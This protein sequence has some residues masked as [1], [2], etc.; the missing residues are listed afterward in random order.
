MVKK[1]VLFFSSR[2]LPRHYFYLSSVLI[3]LLYLKP[4][5]SVW[6]Y[7]D[8]YGLFEKNLL[9]GRHAIK[10]GNL[11]GGIIFNYFS[12]W[13][14][15]S[16]ADLWRLR[17]I[18]LALLLLIMNSIAKE[19]NRSNQSSLIQ[20]ALPLTLMLPAP[21]TFICW[22]L[23]WQGS[24]GIFL[25]FYASQCWLNSHSY[26]RF[27]APV[28]VSAAMTISPVSTFTY[29]GFFSSI[30]ILS[31]ISSHVYAKKLLKLIL[32]FIISG[33]ITLIVLSVYK[34]F[35]D[36]VLNPRVGLVKL[37]DIPEK[38]FWLISRP[39]AVSTR[40]FDIHSPELFN[41]LIVFS[42]VI[43]IVIF[44]IIFQSRE[45]GESIFVRMILYFICLLTSITPIIITWSNQIEYRYI[46]GM[47]WSLFIVTLFLLSEVIGKRIKLT[48]TLT[49]VSIVSVLLAG[50]TTV[51]INT[52]K[53]FIAPYISKYQFLSS[54]IHSCAKKTSTITGVIIMNPQSPFPSRG[55]LG[56]FSQITD[57]ESPWVPIP[58][59][60]AVLEEKGFLN[61]KI[62]VK[63][64]GFKEVNKYC[65]ID[66]EKY[67]KILVASL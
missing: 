49:T 28:I 40:F 38:A 7:S 45:I 9:L 48:K 22:G 52:N 60:K 33:F 24:L 1:L 19:V 58:S 20:F 35:F 4:I 26:K 44:G 67:R 61:V 63:E 36:L 17:L 34:K 27:I 31:K 55:N 16:P 50:I 62:S 21:M 23:L 29:F 53:Q 64:V 15:N 51:S 65:V 54:E 10:D 46:F 11:L 43:G 18:S 2:L 56:I 39:F 12:S 3:I 30:L 66:L 47:S 6:A 14:V 25:T 32:L 57:L 37:G 41:T 13:V 5:F 59:V 42:I 8:E